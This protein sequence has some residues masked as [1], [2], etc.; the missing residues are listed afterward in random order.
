MSAFDWDAMAARETS[1][2]KSKAEDLLTRW[3]GI[4]ERMAIEAMCYPEDK[5]SLED[6][7]RLWMRKW[8]GMLVCCLLSNGLKLI[9]W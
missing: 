9:G 7:I 6:D 1:P 3:D 8:E 2:V 5:E 4:V